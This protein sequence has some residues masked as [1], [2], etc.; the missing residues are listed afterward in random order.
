MPE[1]LEVMPMRVYWVAVTRRK[2]LGGRIEG[3]EEGEVSEWNGGKE[4]NE[5]LARRKVT[6]VI[7]MREWKSG[8]SVGAG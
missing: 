3:K 6:G 8:K 7:W 1:V 2:R 4:E 5:G